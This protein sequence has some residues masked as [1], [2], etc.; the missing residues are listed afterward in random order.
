MIV[1]ALIAAWAVVQFAFEHQQFRS[2]VGGICDA[3]NSDNR[4]TETTSP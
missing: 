1:A 4:A 2:C 3:I